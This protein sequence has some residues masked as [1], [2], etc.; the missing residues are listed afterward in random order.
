MDKGDK[1]RPVTASGPWPESGPGSPMMTRSVKGQQR[2]EK[3][4]AEVSRGSD[5]GADS[6]KRRQ[7][8]SGVV[9][10]V[11]RM[12]KEINFN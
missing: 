12:F 10:C 2:G 1:G 8:M 7:S 9:R 4:K 5:S 11:F 3:G 6:P